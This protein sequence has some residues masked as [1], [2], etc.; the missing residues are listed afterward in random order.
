M[1]LSNAHLE[2]PSNYFLGSSM[3]RG[4][5]SSMCLEPV[6]LSLC[7]ERRRRVPSVD[8][9]HRDAIL[10]PPKMAG[11]SE[12]RWVA[13]QQTCMRRP[14]NLHEHGNLQVRGVHRGSM[15]RARTL[16]LA[17]STQKLHVTAWTHPAPH[18]KWGV[19][20]RTCKN[21]WKILLRLLDVLVRGMEAA[22]PSSGCLKA[23]S[24][25][26]RRPSQSTDGLEA[27]HTAAWKRA[28]YV[29]SLSNVQVGGPEA[30]RESWTQ[31]LAHTPVQLRLGSLSGDSLSAGGAQSPTGLTQRR[32]AAHLHC[33]GCVRCSELR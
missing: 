20:Q 2:I 28:S 19:T 10:C 25:R 7:P 32:T 26:A 31:L 3:A 17:A 11:A 16:W 6:A 13:K 5:A 15:H 33:L 27:P 24:G 9:S 23:G 22:G 18:D 8:P 29:P 21:G 4:S 30:C 1:K 12:Y 14:K